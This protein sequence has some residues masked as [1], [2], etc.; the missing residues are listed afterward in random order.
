MLW[1]LIEKSEPLHTRNFMHKFVLYFH[2][3]KGKQ[4]K[5]ISSKSRLVC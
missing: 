3:K 5:T 2:K 4:N 1:A